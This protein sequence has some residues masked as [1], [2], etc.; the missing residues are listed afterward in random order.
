MNGTVITLYPKLIVDKVDPKIFGGFLE[1]I[2]RAVYEGIYNPTSTH[3]DE[4]GYRKDVLKALQELKMFLTNR[5]KSK[6]SKTII[7]VQDSSITSIQKAETLIG[8]NEKPANSFDK[9]DLVTSKDISETDIIIKISGG[10]AE[11][12]LSPLSFTAITFNL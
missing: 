3:S 10:Q 1:H 9:P 7:R 12:E 4:N 2:G 6:S 8:S 5:H 11:L